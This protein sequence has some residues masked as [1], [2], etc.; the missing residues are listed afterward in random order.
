VTQTVT[1]T[2][3]IADLTPEERIGLIG[4]VAH[5]EVY[6]LDGDRTAPVASQTGTVSNI[7]EDQDSLL[8]AFDSGVTPIAWDKDQFVTRV[9]YA[10][11]A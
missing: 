6:E 1:E 11:R 10:S 9:W 7:A 8:V 3:P 5:V 4:A 2:H